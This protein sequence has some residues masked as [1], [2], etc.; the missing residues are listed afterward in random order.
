MNDTES[1]DLV[2]RALGLHVMQREAA[3]AVVQA[4]RENW[5]YQRFLQ[6]LT[7]REAAER[8]SR[9]VTGLLKRAEIPREFTLAGMDQAK[10]PEKPRRLLPT[11]LSG[12][13]VR[14]GDNLLCFGLPGRG[15][16][17]YCGALARELIHQHQMK[18]WF[19]PAY[20]LVSQLLA[21]KNDHELPQL[22]ERL[23]KFDA[24]YLDDIG[25]VQH[26]ADEMEVLFTFLAERHQQQKT[27]MLTSN[28]VFSE[29]DRVFKSPMTAM[30]AV[31]RL[32][33]RASILEFSREKSHR[34]EAAEQRQ[35]T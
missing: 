10:I 21:A 24:I 7:E 30:A 15:K 1:L 2:L 17:F 34:E 28:L 20:K 9:K 11:L 33:H 13:F 29:W 12:D 8:L 27:L 14:R 23:G 26:S 4:E 3:A 25:Y 32:V 18:V 31:D 19:V 16:S 5:G 35:E 22:L 6:H